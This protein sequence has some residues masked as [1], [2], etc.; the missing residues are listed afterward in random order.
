ME[1]QS[2]AKKIASAVLA[3]FLWLLT[4]GLGLE[5]INVLKNFFT[6]I[7]VGLGGR[8]KTATAIATW[9]VLLLAILFLVFV[10]ATTEYHRKRIG[11]RESWRLF[12]W[13]IASEVS[14]F[15]LYYLVGVFV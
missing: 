9:L 15:I 5:A 3:G 8:E 11:Q 10:I 13:T 6:L 4:F 7:F 1:T 12:G 14:I 2:K